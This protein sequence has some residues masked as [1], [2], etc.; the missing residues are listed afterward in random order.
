M[1]YEIMKY[2]LQWKHIWELNIQKGTYV[3]MDVNKY[4]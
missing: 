2:L 1:K 4:T 3:F